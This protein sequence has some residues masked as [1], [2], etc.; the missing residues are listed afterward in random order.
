MTLEEANHAI[1]VERRTRETEQVVQSIVLHMTEIFQDYPEI[2]WLSRDRLG[3]KERRRQSVTV[4][5]TKCSSSNITSSRR[6]N[7]SLAEG[8]SVD[9]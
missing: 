6:W 4:Q 1:C 5:K 7:V 3:L 9:V 2:D 8:L